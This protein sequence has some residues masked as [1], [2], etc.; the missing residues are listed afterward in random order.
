MYWDNDEKQAHCIR[1]QNQYDDCTY[2]MNPISGT[3]EY[4]PSKTFSLWAQLPILLKR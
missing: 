2:F 1:F 3:V 4:M